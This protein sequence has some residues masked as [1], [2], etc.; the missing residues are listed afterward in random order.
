[1]C[2][3]PGSEC[4]A[5]VYVVGVAAQA[6]GTN[7]EGLQVCAIKKILLMTIVVRAVIISAVGVTVIAITTFILT[8]QALT[9]TFLQMRSP[10]LGRR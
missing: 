7:R 4:I 3:V 10:A 1:M 5:V 8:T 2:A 9:W 6:D